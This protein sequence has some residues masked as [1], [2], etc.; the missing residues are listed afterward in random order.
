MKN[1]K[2]NTPVLP[3]PEM[4]WQVG[5]YNR[6]ATFQLHLPYQFLLLCKIIEVEPE[7]MVFDFLNNLS[8]ESWN[9]EGKDIAKTHLINYF[10]AAGY[11]QEFYNEDA[12]RTIFKE[13]D[14]LGLLFPKKGSIKLVDQYA[15]WRKKHHKYWFNKWYYKARRK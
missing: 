8:C 9:R 4:K 3:P 2:R 13:M 10:L 14:A 12:I 1:N 11:G 7:K 5:P 15:K 6:S